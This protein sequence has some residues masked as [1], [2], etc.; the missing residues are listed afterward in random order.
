MAIGKVLGVGSRHALMSAFIVT[1]YD[2][3]SDVL[4]APGSRLG[5]ITRRDKHLGLSQL[6]TTGVLRQKC[7]SNHLLRGRLPMIIRG[8]Y[9]RQG[10]RVRTFCIFVTQLETIGFI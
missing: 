10:P 9:R 8:L 7:S 1:L 2:V 4:D 3:G 5:T 6:D